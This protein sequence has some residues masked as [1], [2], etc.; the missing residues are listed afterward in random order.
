MS[1]KNTQRQ[2]RLSEIN[3]TLRARN[4]KGISKLGD[5]D[6]GEIEVI[7]IIDIFDHSARFFTDVKFAVKFPNG[8]DGAFTVRFNANG[9][10][11][12]GA[13]IVVLINGKFA[14]LKQWRLPL[15][16]WTYEI[17]RGFGEKLD[18]AHINGELGTLKIGDLPLGT[19]NRELGEE[20]MASADVTSVT[21]LGN[22][23]E[24]SGTSAVA[25]SYFLVQLKIDEK[26]LAAGI[27]GTEQG[28]NVRLWDVTELRRELGIKLCDN[29]SITAAALALGYIAS[30]PC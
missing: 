27:K 10:V 2:A 6:K 13:V 28:I 30:L 19:L 7:S 25:P 21:H 20:V 11:S 16:R 24:N 12:D 22:I 3:S 9:L 26:T 4:L 8:Q 29:H 14:I 1:T 17:P 23:A 5:A 18:D 15:G